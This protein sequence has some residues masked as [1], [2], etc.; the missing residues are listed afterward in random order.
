MPTIRLMQLHDELNQR[1]PLV[2]GEVNALLG[3]PV[4]EQGQAVDSQAEAEPPAGGT[5][6]PSTNGDGAAEATPADPDRSANPQAPAEGTSATN[7]D[8]P[9]ADGPPA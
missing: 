5:A 3:K 8:A 4:T 1:F 6:T 7:A 2:D 9:G